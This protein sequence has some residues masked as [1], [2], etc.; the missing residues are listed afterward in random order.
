VPS[1]LAAR[2][3][4]W[5]VA[6]RSRRRALAAAILA[7][8]LASCGTEQEPIAYSELKQHIDRGDVASVVVGERRIVATPTEDARATGAPA[9]WRA[10]PARPDPG[11]IPLLERK[12][13]R[14]D[15]EGTSGAP[16]PAQ[17]L[18]V[19]LAV[20][21]LTGL[22][23]YLRRNGLLAGVGGGALDVRDAGKHARGVRYADVAGIDEV[24]EELEE[25]VSFLKDP[26]RFSL[27]GARAPKGVLLVGPP[28]TGK[29]LLARATAGE[30]E[31]PFYSVSASSFVEMFVGVGARRIRKLFEKARANTPCI[32][33]IDEL[34]A[35][36]KGRSGG[37][38][39]NDER[40]QTLNQLLVELDGFDSSDGI[41][42][43]AATNRP[44]ILDSALLRPGRFDRRITVN[45][46]DREGRLAI[47][48]VHAR[49]IRLAASVDLDAVARSTPGF[50][51]ADLANLLNEAALLAARAGCEEVGEAHLDA[52]IDRVLAGAQRRGQL[53]NDKERRIV[54]VH[55]TGHAI[56][57]ERSA[58]SGPVRKI[59]I[60][61]RTVGALGF[62]QQL[63]ED[64]NLL[65]R[66]ELIDRLRV[67]LAGR[68]AEE[69]VFGQVSTGAA[70]D[71]ERATALARRMVCEFGMSA[72]LGPVRYAGG[73][74][75]P[76]LQ[77]DRGD[78]VGP[79]AATAADID[80]EIRLLL[81]E[82]AAAARATVSAD[83]TALDTIAEVLLEKEDLDRGEFI[84]YL[85]RHG[86]CNAVRM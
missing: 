45:V 58:T 34:D 54:A 71:L 24:K 57:A 55:E 68:A 22:V 74:M 20:G 32:V 73:S 9:K 4:R 62:T 27:L 6:R 72:T 33:F 40:E 66:D 77:D 43:M 48:D 28:G 1:P 17:A 49:R 23:L 83:R 41:V 31:A 70:N 38:G 11:L 37:V 69:V 85:R 79:S 30:A 25:V 67:L 35:V 10:S 12:G 78:G 76:H 16:H 26:A 46:P 84:E 50:A 60:V 47:L 29:T 2:L 64:R 15:G 5:T 61:P 81:E 3:T 13:V 80:R 86:D 75:A 39:S 42:V 19:L 63:S 82:Q 7:V 21:S 51:G 53:L 65:Q 56:V 59:S 44:E 52:A 14:Y 36:G 8:V 18:L